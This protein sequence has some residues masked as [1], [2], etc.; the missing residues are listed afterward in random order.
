MI[1]ASYNC[2]FS[3][4]WNDFLPSQT[5][6]SKKHL[7]N[8]ITAGNKGHYGCSICL[9][10]EPILFYVQASLCCNQAK[11]RDEKE[12]KMKQNIF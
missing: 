1:R 8:G 7:W 11:H 2:R 10:I 3:G 4:V 12:S 6:I 9:F 5:L